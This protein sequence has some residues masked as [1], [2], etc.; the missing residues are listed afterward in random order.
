MRSDTIK[1]GFERAPHRSLLR[2]T[3]QI[4]DESDFNKPFIAICNSYIDIIPGH[5]H[6]QEF[7]RVVK[8]AVRAAGG[9][10]FEFNTIG[11]DDGIVMGHE[12]MRYS[13]PSRE[14]IA[15]SVE[16]VA[17]SHCFDGMICI[18]NCD[19]IVPGMLMGAA[20]VNIPTIFVSGGPMAAG[21]DEEGNTSDLVTVFEA[22]GK[23]ASGQITDAELL[24]L[25]QIACPT[26]GSCS[27]MFTANSMNCLCE[28]LGVALPGNGT[29]LA[30][31]PERHELARKAAAQIL[32]LVEQNLRFRDIVTAD[33]IDNAMAL[34]VAM[35]G[36]TNT[37]LHVLALARE[38]G[39]NYPIARFNEVSDRV[40]HLAKVS[41]A[42]DGPR[43]WHIQDVH[44]AGGVHAILAELAQKPGALKLD[45]PTVTGKTLGENV[46]HAGVV[47]TQKAA[48]IDLEYQVIRPASN[49]HSKRG[50]LS[51]LFGNLAP[52]GSI[53]KVGA[54]D[55]HEMSF[56]GPAR[57]FDSEEAATNAVVNGTIKPGDVIVVRYEGPRGG[58]GMREMLALT[59]MVKGIPE[60]AGSTALITDGRFSGGTRGLCIGHVSPEAAEGG[61]IG[62]LRDGDTVRIDLAARTLAVDVDAAE[63]AARRA[64]WTPPAPKYQ[65]G[66]LARYTKLVT[67]AI[68]AGTTIAPRWGA[69]RAG[70]APNPA[71]A[72]CSPL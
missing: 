69:R 25:E 63:L 67:N 22:V 33:A 71:Q 35:G 20:R 42:W 53:I 44:E 3:G 49:P 40:P 51:A 43:Q 37:V 14:L 23:R 61:P 15:D 26:C 10:P 52:E 47:R 68:A 56:A 2:A 34:D 72:F 28:A 9:V 4:K 30:I 48:S 57:V 27:G 1:R 17:A 46:R 18:P 32:V 62:L 65:R 5:A 55:Q 8:E 36:S 41:P 24:K 6:L 66:W 21:M 31:A 19:K 60:L 13:L 58:P 54:V 16:T 38:A 39:L 70:S 29:I 64:A 50:A 59:S 12:G 45:V 11:V 7:G